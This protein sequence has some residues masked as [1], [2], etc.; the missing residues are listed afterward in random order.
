MVIR[1]PSTPEQALLRVPMLCSEAGLHSMLKLADDGVGHVFNHWLSVSTHA[2]VLGSL[3]VA[4]PTGTQDS[5]MDITTVNALLLAT[6]LGPLVIQRARGRL[7][8]AALTAGV[9]A[10]GC[11]LNT[12]QYVPGQGFCAKHADQHGDAVATRLLALLEH[13]NLATEA[14]WLHL[15]KGGLGGGMAS[16]EGGSQHTV[17][18]PFNSDEDDS[19]GDECDGGQGAGSLHGGNEAEGVVDHEGAHGKEG[20]SAVASR[21]DADSASKHVEQRQEAQQHVEQ[22]QGAQ[23]HVEQ[24]QG[25]RKRPHCCA[26]ERVGV[27]WHGRHDDEDDEHG[28]KEGGDKCTRPHHAAAAAA[29]GV[30]QWQG[31][32]DHGDNSSTGGGDDKRHRQRGVGLARCAD[33]LRYQDEQ[34]EGQFVLYMQHAKPLVRLELYDEVLIS[35]M[36]LHTITC[37]HRGAGC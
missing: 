37:T 4:V 33:G 19:E 23:K 31:S 24:Q 11:D 12:L 25:S 2:P 17:N 16:S 1:A 15:L 8:K 9:V 34:L 7:L 22:Q 18:G 36:C 10:E 5:T 20:A 35:A 21:S 27:G 30:Y 6:M 26:D 28:D 29:G 3:L 13:S 32:G 14:A